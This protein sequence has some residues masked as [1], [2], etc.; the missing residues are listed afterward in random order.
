MS[1]KLTS[2]S[3][4][5]VIVCWIITEKAMALFIWISEKNLYYNLLPLGYQ[6]HSP[7]IYRYIHFE[8]EV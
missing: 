6:Y 3:A 7:Q 1:Q 5:I 8:E 2:K 4:N